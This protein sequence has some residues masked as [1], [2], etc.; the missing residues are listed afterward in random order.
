[1]RSAGESMSKAAGETAQLNKDIRESMFKQQIAMQ[2]SM[3]EELRAI[4]A[5]DEE[6]LTKIEKLVDEKLQS[7]LQKR[8]GESF[9]MVS[10]QLER[11]YKGIGE[12]QSLAGSVGDLKRVLQNVSVRGAW[13]EARLEAI[14]RENLTAGEYLTNT[15][16]MPNTAERVEFAI[17]LPG[18]NDTPVLLPVDSKFPQADYEK[19]TE[20]NEAGDAAQ[21]EKCRNALARAIMIEA[22]RISDKYIHPPY[23]TDFAVMFLPTEGL[24]ASV[25]TINGIADEMQRKYRVIPSGPTTFTALVTSLR[26]GFRTLAVEQRTTEIWELLGHVRE[27]FYLFGESLDKA[28]KRLEQASGEL[29]GAANRTKAINKTLSDLDTLPGPGK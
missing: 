25:M 3:A 7:S 23:T 8:I 14:L 26:M 2:T 24:F 11:V 28:R 10:E 12:M 6:R 19:L 29:D 20:A 22:K 21:I 5:S 13:G 9:S 18:S 1:M 17:R 27:E 15:P 4:R 16:V